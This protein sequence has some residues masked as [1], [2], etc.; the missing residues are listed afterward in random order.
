VRT[1]PFPWKA[2]MHAGFC[3]LRLSS[4]DFWTLTPL[5]LSAMTG[6]MRP[7]GAALGR[8]GLEALMRAF[9][10]GQRDHSPFP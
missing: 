6:G 1:E 4:R 10:D 8:D 2:A 7:Q 9:P 5:E 3:L